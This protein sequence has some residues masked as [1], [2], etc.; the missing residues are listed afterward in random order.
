[1]LRLSMA[2]YENFF[3]IPI[4]ADDETNQDDEDDEFSCISLEQKIHLLDSHMPD[5]SVSLQYLF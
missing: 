3:K 5:T 4:T 2:V 1:M